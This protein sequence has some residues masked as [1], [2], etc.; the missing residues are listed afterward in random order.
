MKPPKIELINRDK[1]KE[2]VHVHVKKKTGCL[3]I[4]AEFDSPVTLVTQS[5]GEA[6]EFSE[7]SLKL[8]NNITIPTAVLSFHYKMKNDG[9]DVK[10]VRKDL[11]FEYKVEDIRG[12]DFITVRFIDV[13]HPH[14]NETSSSGAG[15]DKGP[16]T[17]VSG[18]TVHY[19]NTD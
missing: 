16:K 12:W 18:S 4:H 1:I 10:D 13:D 2:A 14:D 7:S 5:N 3:A 15:Q 17:H 8:N 19:G 6:Y 9:D 11:S